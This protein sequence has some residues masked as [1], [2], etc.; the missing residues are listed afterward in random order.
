MNTAQPSTPARN[1]AIDFYRVFGV[2][3]IVY[4]HWL[5]ACMTYS[6]GTFNRIDP[7]Q[8][9]PFTQ[10]LTWPFQLVPLFFVVGGYAGALSWKR[11]HDERGGTRQDWIRH[12]MTRMLGP[13]GIYVGLVLVVM[14]VLIPAGV[15][16]ANLDFAGWAVA[17]HLWFLAIY[18]LVTLTTPLAVAAHRR[19]GLWAVAALT[20]AVAAVDALTLFGGVPAYLG[21]VNYLF[22]WGAFYQLGIAWRGGLMIGRRPVILAVGSAVALALLL[23]PGPYPPSMI[24]VTG[25]AI[26]NT[27][28]PTVALLAFG[29]AQ[30]GLAIWA[31]PVLDRWLRTPFKQRVLAFGNANVMALYLWQL[32]PA[33]AVSL[34][35]YPTGLLPQPEVNTT[36]WWLARL[37]WL[38]VLTVVT[39]AEMVLLAWQRKRVSA[40]LPTAPVP[41]PRPL[42]EPLLYAG[43]LMVAVALLGFT[44]S[45][46]APGGH[47][48]VVMAALFAGG[49]A[50][51]A[52]RP[53]QPAHQLN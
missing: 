1:L 44:A 46:F 10:W 19:F 42:V 7:L 5:L 9:I 12:R 18:T 51:V 25:E 15:P 28:P 8:V 26:K 31:A 37:E 29:F 14:A 39:A 13:T 41:V 27:T 53:K 23:G 2:V 6:D 43:G 22:A 17:L 50:L 4:G 21:A 20:A 52:L 33:V 16:G 34:V 36:A 11:W 35:A 47:F 38:V 24:G 40:P 45:G 3:M 32:I 30:A 48:P 49:T